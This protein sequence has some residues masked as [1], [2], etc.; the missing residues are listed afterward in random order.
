MEEKLENSRARLQSSTHTMMLSQVISE[1]AQ[2]AT[3]LTDTDPTIFKDLLM[4]I[5][6]LSLE[7]VRLTEPTLLSNVQDFTYKKRL[8]RNTITKG[9]AP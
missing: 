5:K 2:S 6:A 9:L 4:K 8:I 7:N 1:I 3:E